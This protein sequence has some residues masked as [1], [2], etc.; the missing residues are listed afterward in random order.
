MSTY[1][2]QLPRFAS[3]EAA[4]LVSVMSAPQKNHLQLAAKG[5][6]HWPELSHERQQ[7]YL[8]ERRFKKGKK[9]RSRGEAHGE[10]VSC[11]T[12][13]RDIHSLIRLFRASS[14]LALKVSR[15]RVMTTSLFQTICF[16]ASPLPV[17][18]NFSLYLT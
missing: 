4:G 14:S 2:V 5:I 17:Q 13:N 16:S 7:L 18:K 15:D 9:H 12:M 8:W 11:P 10:M 3:K 6:Y 1:W